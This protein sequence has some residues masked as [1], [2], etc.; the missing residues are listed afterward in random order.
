[1]VKIAQRS[2]R[3]HNSSPRETERG[4]ANRQDARATKT[5][6]WKFKESWD[7]PIIAG[8]WASLATAAEKKWKS[9]LIHIRKKIEVE[10]SLTQLGK[11]TSLYSLIHFFE[12]LEKKITKKQHRKLDFFPLWAFGSLSSHVQFVSL[13]NHFHFFV[14]S[15]AGCS[16]WCW[17]TITVCCW[18]REKRSGEE[19]EEKYMKK[20]V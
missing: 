20:I 19:S 16:C 1:M 18:A 7:F 13:F 11:V 17:F 10:L 5:N 8:H 14:S 4:R 3:K 6:F 15:A 2:T 9:S 12:E